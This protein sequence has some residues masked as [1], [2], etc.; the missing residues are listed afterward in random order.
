[1]LHLISIGLWDENDMSLR[2]LETAKKCDQIYMELYTVNLNTDAKKLSKLIGKPVKC[3]ER[4]ELENGSKKILL[5]AK[6][7]DVAILVGGDALTAT[8]H[9]SLLQEARELGIRTNVVHGSSILTA[10]GE[11]G[12]QLYKFGKVTTL[13]EDFSDSCHETITNNRKNGLHTLILLD[14]G[15]DAKRGLETMLKRFNGNN[16]VVVA[17][18]LGGDATIKYG[19]IESLLKENIK[20][21]PTVIIVPGELHFMEKEFLE[22]L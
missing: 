17:C 8:T 20:K 14:I 3:L 1:M 22:G 11:T 16:K 19:S 4:K 7:N 6:D 2:G 9:I 12:L 13:S 15:M 21:T 18:H 5:Q 10:V